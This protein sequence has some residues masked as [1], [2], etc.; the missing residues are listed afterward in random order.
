MNH[1]LLDQTGILTAEGSK[2]FAGPRIFSQISWAAGAEA[3]GG[4]RGRFLLLRRG[5]FALVQVPQE[6][7]VWAVQQL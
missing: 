1:S 2:A 6:V 5:K 4:P 3:M 7:L